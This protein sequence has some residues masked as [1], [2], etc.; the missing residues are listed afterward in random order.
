MKHKYSVYLTKA[1]QKSEATRRQHEASLTVLDCFLNGR[2]YRKLN[3][4]LA[5]QLRDRLLGVAPDSVGYAISKSSGIRHL[6]NIQGFYR[7][8]VREVGYKSY[9]ISTI[10]YLNPSRSEVRSL[11]GRRYKEAPTLEQVQKVLRFM[12]ATNEVER[13]DR[14]V[15]ALLAATGIRDGA[16]VTLRLGHVD[17]AD[18]RIDQTGCNVATKMGKNITTWFFPVGVQ[19]L[20]EVRDWVNYLRTQKCWGPE[21]PLLPSTRINTG[22]GKGF[23]ADGV[24]EAPWKEASSVRRI[25]REAFVAADLK[26]TTPHRFRDMLVNL[27]YEVCRNDIQA[28][29][30]WSQNLGHEHMMTTLTNYGDVSPYTQKEILQRLR[31]DQDPRPNQDTSFST[32]EVE[33][34]KRLI[35]SDNNTLGGQG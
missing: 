27:A 26:P 4:S 2:D 14:A 11:T 16:L 1:G 22:S 8:L 33:K 19:I 32:E 6:R 9:P 13:R 21:A 15:I 28:L 3:T 18:S 35:D 34:L 17:L 31:E 7:W 12:P 5:I 29:K 23:H 30:T 10:D 25:V 20:T 24:A